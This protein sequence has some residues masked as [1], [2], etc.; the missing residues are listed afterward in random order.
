[1]YH[2]QASPTMVSSGGVG[3]N[4]KRRYDFPPY[5]VTGSDVSTSIIKSES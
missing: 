3:T 5:S 4:K 2:N 1:M